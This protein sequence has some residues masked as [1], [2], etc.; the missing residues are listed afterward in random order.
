VRNVGAPAR[1]AEFVVT[2]RDGVDVVWVGRAD[3]EDV[4]TGED[5]R[6]VQYEG[7][8]PLPDG[9]YSIDWHVVSVQR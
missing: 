5:V 4:D 6:G 8:R 7:D 2:L 3:V 1:T 9:A